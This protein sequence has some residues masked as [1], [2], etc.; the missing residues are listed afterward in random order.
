MVV[1]L[2]GGYIYSEVIYGLY[3]SLTVFKDKLT[4]LVYTLT[5]TTQIKFTIDKE[6]ILVVKIK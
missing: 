3:T 2:S 4:K 1:K 5:A 6:C